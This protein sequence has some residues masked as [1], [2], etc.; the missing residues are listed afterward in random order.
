MHLFKFL[1][2]FTLLVFCLVICVHAE[3]HSNPRPD[4]TNIAD[5]IVKRQA[6]PL[7]DLL[8]QL[9]A[10]NTLTELGTIVNGLAQILG[11]DSLQ[12]IKGLVGDA[13]LLIHKLTGQQTLQGIRG[14]IV[15]IETLV[16]PDFINNTAILID[17]LAPVR[18][19]SL[20]LSFF[21]FFFFFWVRGRKLTSSL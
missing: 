8:N 1:S 16:T 21:L 15:N 2:F 20:F 14:L 6:N 4:S 9:Q 11:G 18:F 3:S 17:G 7:N 5:S 10:G 19:S 12:E 13:S